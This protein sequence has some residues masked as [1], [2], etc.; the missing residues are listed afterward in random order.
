MMDSLKPFITDTITDVDQ[1][2]YDVD[3]EDKHD[4]PPDLKCTICWKLMKDPMQF[5]CGHGTCNYCLQSLAKNSLSKSRPLCPQCRSPIPIKKALKNVMLKRFIEALRVKCMNSWRGCTW[6]GEVSN[7]KDHSCDYEITKCTN[8][9]CGAEI[10]KKS[11]PDHLLK[12]NVKAAETDELK[13]KVKDQSKEITDLK[14]QLTDYE[15]LKKNHQ[16]LQTEQ[17]NLQNVNQFLQARIDV[18]E[19][20]Q[21]KRDRRITNSPITIEDTEKKPF[22]TLEDLECIVISDDDEKNGLPDCENAL[23]HSVHSTNTD[24]N[25]DSHTLH[26]PNA[27]PESPERLSTPFADIE[28]ILSRTTFNRTD[29]GNNFTYSTAGLSSSNDVNELPYSSQ[30]F[31]NLSVSTPLHMNNRPRTPQSLYENNNDSGNSFTQSSNLPHSSSF[32]LPFSYQNSSDT[33]STS[34]IFSP[35][36]FSNIGANFQ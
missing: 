28:S 26:S 27:I 18:L 2:G 17:Q 15:T 6:V 33:A 10:E 34:R 24:A 3:L 23:P 29:S 21:K 5:P 13:Q 30:Y 22:M 12:C 19:T 25:V 14:T 11:L 7:I 8:T 4:L 1:G 9:G 35:Y 36:D 32:F 16:N 20:E 31:N